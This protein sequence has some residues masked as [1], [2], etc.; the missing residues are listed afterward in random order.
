[1]KK[2]SVF[3]SGSGTNAENICDY[4]SSSTKISVALVCTN[5][6]NSFVLERVKK[7]NVPSFVFSKNDLVDTNLLEKKLIESEIDFLILAGFLLKI[8]KKLILLFENRIINIHPSLLP[9]YGGKGMYGKNVHQKVIENNEKKSGITI[10]YV[11]ENYDEGGV[12][13]QK[14]V[15]LGIGENSET[16]SS[17]IQL[18]EHSFFPKIIEKTILK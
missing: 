4:F 11:N 18:L 7:Y 15:E 8:P 5:N 13:F 14:S 17:K 9:K 16:L 3:S 6:E 2:I 10:H 1:M 12:I